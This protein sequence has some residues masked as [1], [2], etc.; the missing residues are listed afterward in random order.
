VIARGGGA[1]CHGR[2]WL[3]GERDRIEGVLCGGGRLGQHDRDGLAHVAHLVVGDD[4]L[5]ERLE[6]RRG[7]LPQRNDG[8]R[9]AD[10][11]RRDDAVHPRL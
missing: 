2:Q 6:G 7:V 8:D 3:D 4:G 9:G 10:L 11:G 1:A 5:L